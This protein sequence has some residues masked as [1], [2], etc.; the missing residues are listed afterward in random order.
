MI[1]PIQNCRAIIPIALV[2]L[3]TPSLPV[4]AS[5]TNPITRMSLE[6]LMNVEVT[7]VSREPERAQNAAAA[8]HVLT[9]EEIQRSGATSLPDALR[10]V[11]GVNVA[12]INANSWA[13]SIRGFNSRFANK[14]LVMIDG[15]SLY[16]PLFSGVFWDRHNIPIDDIDRIEVVRG[17]GG[18]LWGANAVNGVINIIT[19]HSADTQGARLEASVGTERLGMLSGRQGGVIGDSATY[20]L[21]AKADAYDDADI[22]GYD[23][24]NDA[25][26]NGQAHLRVDWAPSARDDMLFEVGVNAISGGDRHA[27]PLLTAPYSE[28]RE[29][30]VERN[31]VYLL[32]RWERRIDP[33]SRVSVQGYLDHSSMDIDSPIAEEERT[34]A[35]VQAQHRTVVGPD[36]NLTWGAGYRGISDRTTTPAFTFDINPNDALI[37]IVNGYVQGSRRF[38]DDRFEFILGTKVEHHSISGTEVQPAVRAV[39]YPAPDHTVWSALS[40]AVRTPSRGEND[41]TV[42]NVVIAPFTNANP[43]A[44]PLTIAI[45]GARDLDAETITAYEIGYR[46]R[47]NENLSFD[48]AGYYNSYDGLLLSTTTGTT[49]VNTAYEAPF[50]DTPVLINETADGRTFG[51]EFAGTWRPLP[52][53]RLRGGYSWLYED[54]DA[55]AGAEGN[56]PRHQVAVQSLYDLSDEWRFDT[57]FRFVDELSNVDADGYVDVD[58]RVSWMPNASVELALTGRNLLTDGRREFGTERVANPSSLA[59]DISRSVFATLVVTF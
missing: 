33:E 18:T 20:R 48:L 39:W 2:A 59:T 41:T 45:Q 12:R 31:D 52:D 55:S 15:R 13:V 21:S 23:D 53:L 16:S 38:F 49:T 40:Q 8:V 35:D 5:D 42:R 7:T 22:A 36:I 19:R 11:P 58:A 32:A 34:T 44:L 9:R 54:L 1:T 37:H 28:V 24:G 50:L 46:G 57:V 17:P 6:Y 14:L 51:M 30:D 25:W 27:A 43:S 26:Q 47:L 10:L 56:A 29:G 3:L 4:S